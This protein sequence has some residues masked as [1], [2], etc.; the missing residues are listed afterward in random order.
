MEEEGSKVRCYSLHPGV[1]NTG[2]SRYMQGGA[3]FRVLAGWLTWLPG[4]KTVEQVGGVGRFW[5]K[6]C[7]LVC[8]TAAWVLSCVRMQ[9]G[10]RGWQYW[11][12]R[13]GGRERP[14]MRR[15]CQRWQSAAEG[16][17]ATA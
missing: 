12:W 13:F 15:S 5:I 11:K 16:A 7:F 17:Q 6:W 9:G 4:V 8:C 2:L 10:C 14:R 1:I 3:A